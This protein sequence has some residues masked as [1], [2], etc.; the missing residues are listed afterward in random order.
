MAGGSDELDGF[1]ES[2]VGWDPIQ[3]QELEGSHAE[4]GGDW[5]G[6]GLVG[7]LEE[8]PDAGVE[9]ELP[10]EESKDEGVSEVAVGLRE[11][12]HA[13]AVEE[14]VGVGGGVGYADEDG[15]GGGTGGGD[16]GVGGCGL[17]L[18]RRLRGSRFLRRVLHRELAAAGVRGGGLGHVGIGEAVANLEDF[19]LDVQGEGI[20]LYN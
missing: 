2:R 4:G 10:A 9:G 14:V 15:E 6:E 3:V 11:G 8:G 16:G 13:G 12:G 1:R 5:G 18:C 19:D 20:S 17:G 7:T